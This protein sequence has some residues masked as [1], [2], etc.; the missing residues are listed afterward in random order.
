MSVQPYKDDEDKALNAIGFHQ[1]I[2]GEHCEKVEPDAVAPESSCLSLPKSIRVLRWVF[3]LMLVLVVLAQIFVN[4]HGN[5]TVDGWF[6]FYAIYG[7]ISCLGM[8]VVAQLL[9]VFLKRP[10]TY[11]DDNL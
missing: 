7:F 6:G 4:I 8:V 2:Y 5:F 3:A 10:D 1:P 11:Y 9:G